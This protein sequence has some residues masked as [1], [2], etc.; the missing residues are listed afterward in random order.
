MASLGDIEASIKSVQTQYN[1]I[2]ANKFY[3]ISPKSFTKILNLVLTLCNSLETLMGLPPRKQEDSAWLILNCCKSIYEIGQPLIWQGNG[4]Y[5]ADS[6]M[7]AAM[8]MDSVINLS[9]TRHLKFRMKIY[10]SSYLAFISQ[11]LSDQAKSLLSRINMI[12]KALRDREEIELPLPVKIQKA[13]VEAET[14]ASVLKCVH[15]LWKE[16]SDFEFRDDPQFYGGPKP[17]NISE[18][19]TVDLSNNIA[20]KPSPFVERCIME[21]VRVQQLT[22]GNANENWKRRSST[23]IKSFSRYM[24]VNPQTVLNFSVKC[25]V[26]VAAIALFDVIEGISV[27]DFIRKIWSV[28]GQKVEKDSSSV[29]ADNQQSKTIGKVHFADSKPV[30]QNTNTAIDQD[31]LEYELLKY[32]ENFVTADSPQSKLENS[33]YLLQHLEQQIQSA[34]MAQRKSLLNRLSVGIW[35]REIYPAL[36]SGLSKDLSIVSSSSLGSLVLS[37]SESEKSLSSQTAQL[38][39]AALS[40]MQSF[41]SFLVL[42]VRVLDI[43]T[44]HDP[45]LMASVALVTAHLL[46]KFNEIRTCIA[47]LRRSIEALE[48]HRAARVDLLVHLPEEP[49]DVTA[50][51]ML[52]FSVDV[53]AED[54]FSATKRLGAHAFAGYGIFGSGASSTRLDVAMAE[55]HTDLLLLYFGVETDY[56]AAQFRLRQA[57]RA[58][59]EQAEERRKRAIAE[60]GAKPKGSSSRSRS[61]VSAAPSV[62]T[63]AGG[64]S[65]V[66]TAGTTASS[67]TNLVVEK[68]PCVRYLSSFIGQCP[69]SRCLLALTLARIESSAALRHSRLKEAEEAI[70]EA[71]RAEVQLRL[72]FADVTLITETDIRRP[73]L[74]ARTHRCMYLMPVATRR[75]KRASYF[76]VFGK[77]DFNSVDVSLAHTGMAGCEVQ[78]SL[79]RF[80]SPV[81]CTVPFEGLQ[82]GE[83]YLFASAAFTEQGEVL[84][85]GIGPSTI[86][87]IATNPLPTV[88]LWSYLCEV[89]R[90]L[91]EEEVCRAAGY[92]VNARFFLAPDVTYGLT[93]PVT[94]GRAVNLFFTDEPTLCMLAVQQASPV[95]LSHFVRSFLMVEALGLDKQVMQARIESGSE[96]APL[97]WRRNSSVQ[98][99]LV[100]RL[101]KIAAVTQVAVMLNSLDLISKCVSLGYGVVAH[102][103]HRDE[104]HLADYALNPLLVFAS[105]LQHIPLKYWGDW[106]HGVYCRLLYHVTRSAFLSQNVACVSVL[107]NHFHVGAPK[108]P[109]ATPLI[110]YEVQCAYVA[111]LPSLRLQGGVMWPATAEGQ[112]QALLGVP[113]ERRNKLGFWGITRPQRLYLLKGI[114]GALVGV[115]GATAAAGLPLTVQQVDAYL[116]EDAREASLYLEV[117]LFLAKELINQGDRNYVGKLLYLYPLNED[118]LTVPVKQIYLDWRLEFIQSRPAA[119]APV[120]KAAASGAT[121]ADKGGAGSKS[122]PVLPEATLAS[123]PS[124]L[125]FTL[126]DGKMQMVSLAALTVTAAT[127]C[128]PRGSKRN[129]TPVSK[130]GPLHVFDVKDRQVKPGDVLEEEDGDAVGDGGAGAD[131]VGGGVE[132]PL[133]KAGGTPSTAVPGSGATE[134][135][136]SAG[137]LVLKADDYIRYLMAGVTTLLQ[138]L[139]PVAAVTVALTFWT[140]ITDEWMDAKMFATKFIGSQQSIRIGMDALV[141]LLE[142]ICGI[143]DGADFKQLSHRALEDTAAKQQ[144]NGEG[145][146]QRFN[147][148]TATRRSFLFSLKDMF[149]FMIQVFWIQ[150]R[151]KDVVDLG[152]RVVV[153]YMYRLPE[154]CNR[155]CDL[156]LNFVLDAQQQMIVDGQKLKVAREREVTVFV[157]E[158]TEAQAKLRKKKMRI[159]RLEKSEEELK[160]EADRDALQ[161]RANRAAASLS[162]HEDTMERL[163]GQRRQFDGMWTMGQTMLAKV[164]ANKYA[165]LGVCRDLV[166]GGSTAATDAVVADDDPRDGVGL[167]GEEYVN[168]RT[169]LKN[170]MV[171]QRLNEVVMQYD[172][173]ANFLREHKDRVS[174]IE[175]LTDEG[176][177]LLLFG[178]VDKAKSIWMD[179]VD[180]LFNRMDVVHSWRPALSDPQV[181]RDDVI[182]R[183]APAA[184]II[185]G[186]SSK[187]T[188]AH[189]WDMKRE[190]CS[191]AAELCRILF[192]GS[193]GH[194]VSLHGFATYTCR[195][196]GGLS[197]LAESPDRASAAG[198]VAALEEVILVLMAERKFIKALPVVVLLEH[199]HGAYTRRSDAW[200]SARIQRIRMLTEAGLLAEAASALAGISAT[201]Q[202]IESRSYCYPFHTIVPRPPPENVKGSS[203]SLAAFASTQSQNSADVGVAKNGLEF[204]HYAPFFN[205]LPPHDPTTKLA[206]DWIAEYP[207]HFR[208]FS[209]K[210]T[211]AMVPSTSPPVSSSP[212]P[213]S[214]PSPAP[215]APVVEPAAASK[216]SAKEK[217]TSKA[218][219]Q[220]EAASSPVPAPAPAPAQSPAP[221]PSSGSHQEPTVVQPTEPMFPSM[222]EAKISCECARL[223]FRLVSHDD[224][225]MT[226]HHQA[227]KTITSS[228]EELLN[229]ALKIANGI[230]TNSKKAPSGQ[231]SDEANVLVFKCQLIKVRILL[232]TRNLKGANAAVR[233][234]LQQ[235]YSTSSATAGLHLAAERTQLWYELRDLSLAMLEQGAKFKEVVEFSSRFMEEVA[236]TCCS[237]WLR[238]FLGYRCNALAKLGRIDA[239]LQ[240]CDVLRKAFTDTEGLELNLGHVRV[241]VLQASL[242]RQQALGASRSQFITAIKSCR[243]IV[244]SAKSIAKRVAE[245]YGFLG[246]ESN[247][248]FWRTSDN[249]LK[250]AAKPTILYNISSAR[251][252][253]PSL[254]LQTEA[255]IKHSISL[256]GNGDAVQDGGKSTVTDKYKMKYVEEDVR[257][258]LPGPIDEGDVYTSSE[259]ASIY[260]EPVKYLCICVC[261]LVTILDDFRSA[262]V[263]IMSDKNLEGS[264]D[265]AV[266]RDGARSGSSSL[267]T[268]NV[269]SSPVT[270]DTIAERKLRVEELLREESSNCEEGLKVGDRLVGN[271]LPC[272]CSATAHTSYE[273]VFYFK[274]LVADSQLYRGVV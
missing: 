70:E 99:A 150:E 91:G 36:Q 120:G 113:A 270:A 60:A 186:K 97:H 106:D 47:L 202:Q 140:F 92:R 132:S 158:W 18:V 46:K 203:S 105:A 252:N 104:V 74:L 27:V 9:T 177:M 86:P 180:G 57:T 54:W 260:L 211:V 250:H 135:V 218:K 162:Q 137:P 234:L 112:L 1:N 114:A 38:E 167:A 190:Y 78:V 273:N 123:K 49:R 179:A 4:R 259:F 21:C 274:Y 109:P 131:G 141:R 41:T 170:D 50:L 242:I 71:E 272:P 213:V 267:R 246:V 255:E 201:V 247:L 26:E 161:E 148:D 85:H 130:L 244:E 67:Q 196:L 11:G 102:I 146:L 29:P 134:A 166:A 212:A 261:A 230:L 172:H 117:L 136:R 24:D 73:V 262:E 22:A 204:Y 210:F 187:F 229:S 7:F 194:P 87:V 164:K 139:M 33:V 199:Y 197:P 14:D 256:Q 20:S 168:Y 173:V 31:L 160:F 28:V 80:T 200:L 98:T 205:N 251:E 84:G 51:Q 239:A 222:Y 61:A 235:M 208:E 206:V 76:R 94:M 249:I 165:L 219:K 258:Y 42:V 100:L 266:R 147:I 224:R 15:S 93:P 248:T 184:I 257:A 68:L 107:L 2:I 110:S 264:E 95:L 169:C 40:E 128:F 225:V 77:E 226:P 238:V 8:A 89:A 34:T 53:T 138:S 82:R 243:T 64:A 142:M 182:V 10:T 176:D 155:V 88:L 154:F 23:I 45:V 189:D 193:M 35:S 5:V 121:K 175:A 37:A 133:V 25:F 268:A 116:R 221:A 149:V 181:L 66:L 231:E 81:N 56:G 58:R 17:A 13:L 163:L 192:N 215:T 108:E 96:D 151:W 245:E 227:I 237:Y 79:S 52:S 216:K 241:L 127:A 153:L 254:Y 207:R 253:Y 191:M 30:L 233:K 111:S 183:C 83:K 157:E 198:L 232:H 6:L 59:E 171:E 217:P 63:K 103:L 72:H 69:Y 62:G 174:L 159:A 39:V 124:V 144:H 156:C 32:F 178:R 125:S 271:L 12:C 228:S 209:S 122:Q 90:D 43:T 152:M 188:A 75:L 143:P 119:I 115:P 3:H 220:K 223:L 44:I 265:A 55:L 16:S 126:E 145:V 263:A 129:Y 269:G 48:E 236:A 195:E 240:D 214:A 19:N 118:W 65:E 101:R 185:L